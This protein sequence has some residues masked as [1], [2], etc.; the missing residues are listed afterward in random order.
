MGY[1]KA[2]C[3]YHSGTLCVID[4]TIP[5]SILKKQLTGLDKL[6]DFLIYFDKLLFGN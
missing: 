2:Q 5:V 6:A 3:L 1:M 4:H